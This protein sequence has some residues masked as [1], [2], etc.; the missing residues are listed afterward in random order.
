MLAKVEADEGSVVLERCHSDKVVKRARS[1]GA[2]GPGA[3][4]P[5]ENSTSVDKP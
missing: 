4:A 5:K 2:I 3:L 1:P